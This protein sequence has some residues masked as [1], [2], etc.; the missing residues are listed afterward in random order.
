MSVGQL[1]TNLRRFYAEARNI[2]GDVYSKS[3]LLCF[4]NGIERYLNAPPLNKGLKLTSDSRRGREGQRQ[5][6]KSSF[7]FEVDP[8]GRNYATM[9]HDEATKN[10]PGGV[11]DVPSAKKYARMYE[12]EDVNDGYKA[13][14]SGVPKTTSGTKRVVGVNSLDTMM[15]NISQAAS[16]SQLYTNHSVRATAITVWSNAGI[17]NRQWRSP[18]TEMSKALL[19]TTRAYPLPSFAIIVKYYQEALSATPESSSTTSA[20]SSA[21]GITVRQNNSLVLA[22]E[23]SAR[24]LESVFT[25]CTATSTSF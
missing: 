16:L 1:D 22:Q 3:T 20:T 10:H 13:L 24:F 6:K 21:T 11:A 9:A 23:R 4:R 15:K 17:P 7:K 14:R 19:I 5:L 8:A 18:G 25:N 2:S 12:T